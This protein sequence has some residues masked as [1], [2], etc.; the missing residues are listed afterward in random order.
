MAPFLLLDTFFLTSGFFLLAGPPGEEV[1]GTVSGCLL[2][3]LGLDE[4]LPGS[5]SLFEF[6]TGLLASESVV[7]SG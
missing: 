6:G 2:G 1:E 3:V 4:C 5:D 7:A